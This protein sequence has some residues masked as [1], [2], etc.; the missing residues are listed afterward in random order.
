[1]ELLK[2]PEALYT[3]DRAEGQVVYIDHFD[4]AITSLEGK[5]LDKS[6]L[7]QN[8]QIVCA[9]LRIPFVK[10]FG[11]VARGE[12]LAYIG[13]GGRLEIAV[14]GGSAAQTLKLRIGC[15]IRVALRE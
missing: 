11:Q 3:P 2:K 15:K 10:T 6:G 7:G 8:L 13:S 9:N 14:N 1:M 4:N 12:P 5:P